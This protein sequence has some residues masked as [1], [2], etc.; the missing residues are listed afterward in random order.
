MSIPRTLWAGWIVLATCATARAQYT[1]DFEGP[2]VTGSPG[3]TLMTGQ[4]GWINPVAGSA[5]FNAYTYAGNALGIVANASGSAQMVAGRFPGLAAFARCQH[6]TNF[7]AGGIWT[8]TWDCLGLYTG[9]LPTVDNLGSFSLQP[10]ATARYW[11]QVMQWGTANLPTATMYNINYGVWDTAPYNQAAPTFLSPGPA[12]TNIPANHWIRQSTT[13]D[14]TANRILSVSITDLTANTPTV[15][16][17]VSA[18]PYHLR[19]GPNGAGPLP[20]DIRI[21]AGGGAGTTVDGGNV[22]AWDN[23]RVTLACSADINHSGTVNVDDMLSVI[24]SWGPCPLPC[25]PHCA[26]DVAPVGG[27]CV[28]NVDDLLMVITHWGPCP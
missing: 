6:A 1:T 2:A 24:T 12:W 22:T 8:A 7:S 17:D 20:T 26:A 27:D 25:P 13:W 23:I 3:G 21:F 5:D 4:D 16:V 18:L 9:I 14:F 10:S 19:F 15:T 28:V 11:Q